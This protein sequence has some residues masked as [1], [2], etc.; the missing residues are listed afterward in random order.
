[1]KLCPFVYIYLP[2]SAFV[3]FSLLLYVLVL[4]A[5]TLSVDLSCLMFFLDI[6]ATLD[7]V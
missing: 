2:L 5:S 3:L 7:A 1:M 4:S 6:N